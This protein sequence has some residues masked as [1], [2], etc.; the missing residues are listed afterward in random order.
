MPDLPPRT[1][2]DQPAS[3]R[4]RRSRRRALQRG[5][6]APQPAGSPEAV[7]LDSVPLPPVPPPGPPAVPGALEEAWDRRKR[8]ALEVVDRGIDLTKPLG[9]EP[10]EYRAR[11]VAAKLVLGVQKSALP[12]P[13]FGE[14]EAKQG[15]RT[16]RLRWADGRMVNMPLNRPDPMERDEDG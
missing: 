4:A 14:L 3:E 12:L 13:K 16:I 5:A 2:P 6:D 1:G 15:D 11:M 7:R 9:M 8:Q 10:D